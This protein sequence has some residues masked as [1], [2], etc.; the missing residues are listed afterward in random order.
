MTSS[1]DAKKLFSDIPV[2]SK[3]VIFL[4]YL[5]QVQIFCPCTHFSFLSEQPGG[6][7]EKSSPFN[8]QTRFQLDFVFQKFPEGWKKTEKEI[9]KGEKRFLYNFIFES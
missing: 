3:Y 9:E 5:S 4:T 7:F 2:K 8:F 6:A 1:S